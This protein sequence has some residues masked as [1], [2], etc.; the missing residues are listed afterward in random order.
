M[1][2]LKGL[3]HEELVPQI[4]RDPQIHPEEPLEPVDFKNNNRG[5][6]ENDKNN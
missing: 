1:W 5:N 2:P 4:C 6:F 3:E